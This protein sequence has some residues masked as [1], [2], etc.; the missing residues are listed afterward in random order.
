[1]YEEKVHMLKLKINHYLV[2]L[3][4]SIH[5]ASKLIYFLYLE[6]QVHFQLISHEHLA[7]HQEQEFFYFKFYKEH[8]YSFEEGQNKTIKVL[9]YLLLYH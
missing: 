8:E 1:M 9:T 7:N 3:F 5:I 2:L 6:K 4:D